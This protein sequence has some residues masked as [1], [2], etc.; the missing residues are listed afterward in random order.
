[1]AD[2]EITAFAADATVTG[3]EVLVADDAGTGK[4]ITVQKVSDFAVTE[5]EGETTAVGP[6]DSGDSFMIL[7]NDTDLKPATYEL[8]YA[9][10]KSSLYDETALGAAVTADDVFIMRDGGIAGT[11]KTVTAAYIASYMLTTLEASILDITDLGANATPAD[12]DLVMVASGTTPKKTTWAQLKAQVLAGFK[13]YLIS[14]AAADVGGDTDTFYVTQAGVEKEMTLLQLKTYI[15]ATL[16]GSGTA[17]SFARWADSDTLKGDIAMVDSATGFAVGASSD[18]AVPTTAAVRGEMDTI[19]YDQTDIGA[20]LADADLIIVDDGAAGTTQRKS[21]FTRV[22]TWITT[23]IQALTA[24]TTPTNADILTIQDAADSNT[25]KELTLGNA[26]KGLDVSAVTDI[27]AVIVD[28]DEILI[29]DGGGGTT[30]RSDMSRVATYVKTK[31]SLVLWSPADDVSS[32]GYPNGRV[33]AAAGG[34]GECTFI[35]PD[36]VSSVTSIE[37][38]FIPTATDATM[39]LDIGCEGGAGGESSATHSNSEAAATYAVTNGQIFEMD[40]TGV[41][42]NFSGGDYVQFQV[43]NNDAADAIN[44]LGVKFVY[45]PS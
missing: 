43:I 11:D 19:V 42:T 28:A 16:D 38:V 4:K 12:A 17:D 26:T 32:G 7:E 6:V 29:D 45:V 2:K 30:R 10:L 41:M 35:Y 34:I 39:D 36:N 23:K 27:G 33:V 9:A 44:L 3:V 13:E 18:L 8:V 24:K 25:L 40:I 31:E 20:A 15:A 5:I 37:A 14:L 21:T 1:M 22:W